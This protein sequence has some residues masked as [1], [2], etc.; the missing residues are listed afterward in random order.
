LASRLRQNSGF[1]FGDLNVRPKLMVLHNLFFLILTVSVYLSLI[2]LFESRVASA[3][4]RELSL[5]TKLFLDDR[6]PDMPGLEVYDYREGTAEALQIPDNILNWLELHPGQIYRDSATQ[7]MYRLIPGTGQ[8]RRLQA[9]DIFYDSVVQRAKFTI[10]LVLG[11]LYA[12]AIL[13]L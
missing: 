6:P 12:L 4:G 5:L 8:F 2:P 3:K 1:S 13:V 10:F 11:I 9:P 7:V